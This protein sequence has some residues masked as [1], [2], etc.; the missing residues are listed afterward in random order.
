MTF[1]DLLT[2]LVA[3]VYAAWKWTMN[4][5]PDNVKTASLLL[6]AF[7]TLVLSAKNVRELMGNIRRNLN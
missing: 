4:L 3:G 1:I 6:G 2:P 5:I 7:F